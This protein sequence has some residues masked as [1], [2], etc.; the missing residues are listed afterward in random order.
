[1]ILTRK[2]AY[3]FFFFAGFFLAAFLAMLCVSFFGFGPA[4]IQTEVR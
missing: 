3:F 2:R 4:R 1:M